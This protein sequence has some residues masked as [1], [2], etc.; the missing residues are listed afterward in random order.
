[1]IKRNLEELFPDEYGLKAYDLN[2]LEINLVTV[3][4]CAK[5]AERANEEFEFLF[6]NPGKSGFYF[7][8]WRIIYAAVDEFLKSA[9]LNRFEEGRRNVLLRFQTHYDMS[10]DVLYERLGVFDDDRDDDQTNTGLGRSTPN[11]GHD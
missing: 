4:T 1:M 2:T 11:D 6:K 3:E 7:V 10:A 9:D 8:D 5:H